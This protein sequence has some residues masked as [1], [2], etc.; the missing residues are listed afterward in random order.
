VSERCVYCLIDL[1]C[2]EQKLLVAW[3]RDALVPPESQVYGR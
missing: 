2:E 1:G 3:E